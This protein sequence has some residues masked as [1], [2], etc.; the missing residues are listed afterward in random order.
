MYSKIL[1]V[2]FR[3]NGQ[4]GTTGKSWGI[5]NNNIEPHRE[6]LLVL[7]PAL[8]CPPAYLVGRE[9]SYRPA[10]APPEALP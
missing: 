5:A 1:V 7:S 3:E 2:Y 10:V 4:K 9:Y 6:L 8:R